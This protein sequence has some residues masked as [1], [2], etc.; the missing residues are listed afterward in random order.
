MDDALG[1]EK[2]LFERFARAADLNREAELYEEERANADQP[3]EDL[4]GLDVGVVGATLA[5]SA[6]G[7]TPFNSCNDRLYDPKTMEVPAT[8]YAR[9]DPTVLFR[10]RMDRAVLEAYGWHDIANKVYCEFLLDYEDEEETEDDGRARR[11]KKPWRYR[12]P[13]EIRDEVLAR[14]LALNAERAKEEKLL[15]NL[16]ST[17]RK[18][19]SKRIKKIEDSSSDQ[20]HIVFD[21]P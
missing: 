15:G 11:R 12:W 9:M 3:E 17:N 5:L 19:F 6:L 18:K 10:T 2:A 20:A 16:T 8:F 13:D 7:A 1:R 14:L 21:E 4:W